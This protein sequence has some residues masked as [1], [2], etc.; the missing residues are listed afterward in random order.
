[1]SLSRSAFL[2]QRYY[3]DL[4]EASS[5]SSVS[6]SLEGEDARVSCK[7]DD[8]VAQVPRHAPVVRTPSIQPGVLPQA[9]PFA[10]SPLIHGS[11]G[12]MGTTTST[13]AGKIIPQGADSTMLATKTVKHGAPGPSHSLSAPQAAAAA[14]LRRQMASQAPAVSTLTESTLKNVPQVVNVQELKT[15]PTA[16]SAAMGSS[17]PYSA[18]KTSHPTMT[19]A[20]ANQ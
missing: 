16:A 2:S 17:V 14:A 3:E 18:A 5:T 15:N 8:P 20:A 12:V 19:P 9:T 11:P 13:S 7:D 1:A 6:Q 4:D 10:K